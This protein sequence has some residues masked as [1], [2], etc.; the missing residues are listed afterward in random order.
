MDIEMRILGEE[1]EVG[2]ILKYAFAWGEDRGVGLDGNLYILNKGD[3]FARQDLQVTK[4]LIHI[5]L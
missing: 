5:L 2:R 1:A 4:R 3:F